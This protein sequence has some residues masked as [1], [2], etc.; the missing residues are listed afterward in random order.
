M[1]WIMVINDHVDCTYMDIN[2]FVII[3]LLVSKSHKHL[4]LVPSS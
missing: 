3:S 1:F 4:F 2:V